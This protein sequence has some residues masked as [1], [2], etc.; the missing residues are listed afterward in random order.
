MSNDYVN[1]TIDILG[2]PYQI[3]CPESEIESLQRSAKHLE[4]QMRLVRDVGQ[5]ISLDRVAVITALNIV[6]E[7]LTLERENSHQ[8]QAIHQRLY[9][10]QDRIDGALAKN[11]QLE[12]SPA[13]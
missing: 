2:K 7:L 8:L 9:H 10:L 4:E 12:L 5:V 1:T 6:H 11:Q 13:D 3:K